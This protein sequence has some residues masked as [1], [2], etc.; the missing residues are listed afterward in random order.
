[1]FKCLGMSFQ[2]AVLK[3]DGKTLEAG[4]W[5]TTESSPQDLSL[6][7]QNVVT[8]HVSENGETLVQEA[9]T[10]EEGTEGEQAFAQI[11]IGGYETAREFSVVEQ[12]AEEIHSTATALRYKRLTLLTSLVLLLCMWK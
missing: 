1:M 9:L 7:P 5:V 11:A 6:Q 8:Y 3:S 12:T 2:V 10:Q 4:S